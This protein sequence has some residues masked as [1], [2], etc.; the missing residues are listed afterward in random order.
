MVTPLEKVRK[1]LNIAKEPIRPQAP[2]GTRRNHLRN[3]IQDNN[4]ILPMDAAILSN[5]RQTATGS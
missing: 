4:A 2:I 3:F 1:V 5:L